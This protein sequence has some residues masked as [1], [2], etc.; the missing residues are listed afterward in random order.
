MA[1]DFSMQ[2]RLV[3]LQSMLATHTAACA[4]AGL[5][6]AVQ[7]LT[8]IRLALDKVHTATQPSASV[9]SPAPSRAAHDKPMIEVSDL[10]DE[11]WDEYLRHENAGYEQLQAE[12]QAKERAQTPAAV[13]LPSEKEAEMMAEIAELLREK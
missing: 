7:K 1:R 4:R 5:H 2:G 10:T 3:R 9:P 12:E 11:Q 6:D 8:E 13:P